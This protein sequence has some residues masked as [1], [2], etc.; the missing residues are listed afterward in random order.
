MISGYLISA[1]RELLSAPGAGRLFRAAAAGAADVTDNSLPSDVQE[2]VQ[3]VTTEA[4][5]EVNQFVQFF[6]DHIPDLVAFGVRVL[7]A[8]IL[9]FVGSKS[10]GAAGTHPVLCG[11]QDHQM[12]PKGCEE[13]L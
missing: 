7:L 2:S 4:T 11:K 8:L 12:D 6:E 9:F 3:E 5:R 10:P 13:I 1:V